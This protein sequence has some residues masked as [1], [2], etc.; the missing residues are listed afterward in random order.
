MATNQL[1]TE[2]LISAAVEGAERIE[3]LAHAIEDAG[4]DA[5][6]LREEG[7]RLVAELA[8]LENQQALITQFTRLQEGSRAAAE[9]FAEAEAK[10]NRLASETQAA[11]FSHLPTVPRYY[12][13]HLPTTA[14]TPAL[15]RMKSPGSRKKSTRPAARRMNSAPVLRT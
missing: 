6:K 1:R 9:A 14:S 8:R 15:C 11:R 7:A 13:Q 3:Q 10:L 12:R 2:L 4:G 5:S